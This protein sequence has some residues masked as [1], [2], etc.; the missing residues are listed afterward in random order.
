LARWALSL[1]VI[2][3]L[4]NHFQLAFPSREAHQDGVLTEVLHHQYNAIHSP[5]SLSYTSNEK[6]WKITTAI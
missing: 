1:R 4:R 5:R 6:R 2:L 3:R